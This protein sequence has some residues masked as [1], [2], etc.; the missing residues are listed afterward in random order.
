[1]TF[2]FFVALAMK[3]FSAMLVYFVA[4][5]CILFIYKRFVS[6]LIIFTAICIVSVKLYSIISTDMSVVIL[7]KS[8]AS[9]MS[10]SG[11]FSVYAA[12]VDYIKN[13]D[14][15]FFLKGIGLMAER[16]VISKYD[17]SWSINAHNAMLS[18]ILG[19]GILGA[20]ICLAF[21]YIPIRAYFKIKNFLI[22]LNSF[23]GE[24]RVFLVFFF[25]YHIQNI[26]F[27]FT[28]SSYLAQASYS[29]IFIILFMYIAEKIKKTYQ[30]EDM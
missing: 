6:L 21:W 15:M 11:R 2:I 16:A 30:K 29:I 18:S 22:K 13:A 1:M 14:T 10:G 25:C 20:G 27:S 3:S 24:Y 26:L 4:F 9:Y 8:A 7:N 28:N 17:V 12:A 23:T 5:L 19:L